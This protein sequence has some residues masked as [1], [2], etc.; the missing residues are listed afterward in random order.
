MTKDQVLQELVS[1]YRGGFAMRLA[2]AY[3][4]ADSTNA[5]T[6]EQAFPHIFSWTEE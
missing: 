2:E 1:G 4:R 6:L 5:H 3:Y